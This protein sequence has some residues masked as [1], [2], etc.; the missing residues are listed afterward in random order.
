MST[1]GIEEPN[2]KCEDCG[3]NFQTSIRLTFHGQ[4]CVK[5]KNWVDDNTVPKGW[6]YVVINGANL[7]KKKRFLHPDGKT[8]MFRKEVIQYMKENNYADE[9]VDKFILKKKKTDDFLDEWIEDQDQLPPGWKYRTTFGLDGKPYFYYQTPDGQNLQGKGQAEKYMKSN[10]Y[11]EEDVKKLQIKRKES[12][13][14]TENDA[15]IPEGWKYR[16]KQVD[17][18]R[19]YFYYL[20][21]DGTHLAGRKQ[22]SQYIKQKNLPG[23]LLKEFIHFN[24]RI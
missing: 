12:C 20:A 2:F 21:P 22:V 16:V 5:K 11:S 15:S 19:K 23:D 17:D 4:L 7:S 14:W 3:K 6:K 24:R 18:G 10:N 9:D 1:H 8:V 13:T